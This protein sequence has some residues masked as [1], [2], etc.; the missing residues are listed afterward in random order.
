MKEKVIIFI[1]SKLLNEN[2]LKEN[3]SVNIETELQKVISKYF[4]SK[5]YDVEIYKNLCD[6]NPIDAKDFNPILIGYGIGATLLEIEKKYKRRYLVSP[7][8]MPNFKHFGITESQMEYNAENTYFFFGGKSD[9]KRMAKIVSQYY[10]QTTTEKK[11]KDLSLIDI[12]E[13]IGLYEL[14]FHKGERDNQISSK[15]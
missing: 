5:V 12:I 11:G 9:D 7:T 14:F 13:T 8:Y 6:F 15:Q 4:P 3:N 2:S 1:D 10:P